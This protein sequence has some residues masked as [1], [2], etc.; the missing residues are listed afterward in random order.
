[1]GYCCGGIETFSRP[2]SWTALPDHMGYCCGGIETNK[3]V[4]METPIPM[5]PH[6]L[7]LRRYWDAINPKFHSLVLLTTWVTAA[8][9]LRLSYFSTAEEKLG[10]HGLLL[11]RY[12]DNV[13]WSLQ[14]SIHDHMGYCCGGIETSRPSTRRNATWPHGL[15]LIQHWDNSSVMYVVVGGRP[16]MYKCDRMPD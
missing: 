15:L 4:S 13:V 9:V 6:G 5:R 11:R 14:R 8:A 16:L 2:D 3:V 7:L 1:M 10:P 12:W